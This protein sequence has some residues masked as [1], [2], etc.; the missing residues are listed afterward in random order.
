[1]SN[2]IHDDFDHHSCCSVEFNR[3]PRSL[4]KIIKRRKY[5]SL[6]PAPSYNIQNSFTT[7]LFPDVP[8]FHSV[9]ELT[10]RPS[11]TGS[12]R[13]HQSRTG[14]VSAPGYRKITRIDQ[15]SSYWQEPSRALLHKSCRLSNVD[16]GRVWILCAL[17]NLNE[18]WQLFAMCHGRLSRW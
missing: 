14:K 1:M 9:S 11:Q 4:S 18:S 12:S 6:S 3:I 8:R 7:S 13:Y 2:S 5:H 15:P 16:N 17:W 10:L